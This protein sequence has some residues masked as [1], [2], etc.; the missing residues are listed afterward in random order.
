MNSTPQKEGRAGKA[1]RMPLDMDDKAHSTLKQWAVF[2][3][4]AHPFWSWFVVSVVHLRPVPGLPYPKL[5]DARSQWE[6]GVLACNLK[7]EREF[8]MLRPETWKVMLPPN[9]MMQFHGPL[10]DEDAMAVVDGLVEAFVRG[11]VSPDSDARGSHLLFVEDILA[12]V[13][14]RAI[15]PPS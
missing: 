14:G 1:W 9:S 10:G 4:K 5:F 2:C 11:Q 12:S 8:D 6:I 15:A 13:H 3:P 7:T